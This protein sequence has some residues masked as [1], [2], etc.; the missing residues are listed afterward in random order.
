MVP[1]LL[2]CSV[3]SLSPSNNFV[4]VTVILFKELGNKAVQ[5]FPSFRSIPH[6]FKCANTEGIWL[7]FY[8]RQ[9]MVHKQF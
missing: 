6:F 3:H 8:S 9:T 1:N 5:F 7:P 4:A 2:T